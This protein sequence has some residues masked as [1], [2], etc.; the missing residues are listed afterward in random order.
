ASP[1]PAAVDPPRSVRLSTQIVRVCV[2]AVNLVGLMAMTSQRINW[3]SS[4][5]NIVEFYQ[6]TLSVPFGRAVLALARQ[7]KIDPALIPPW[8]PDYLPVA[9]IF[10]FGLVYGMAE[11]DGQTQLQFYA[12]IVKDLFR[13]LRTNFWGSLVSIPLTII[14]V[15]F[16]ALTAPAF[17]IVLPCVV[18]LYFVVAVGVASY[19]YG[20]IL[21]FVI[22]R[23]VPIVTLPLVIVLGVWLFVSEASLYAALGR[24]RRGSIRGFAR[25]RRTIRRTGLGVVRAE[26]AKI[27]TEIKT[28]GR[29]YTTV[30]ITQ[31][32]IAGALIFL[33]LTI[34]ALNYA[35]L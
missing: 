8:L 9:S 24:F 35:F 19:M 18:I 22:V 6:A 31:F 7:L 29:Q 20:S 28:A 13:E 1:A 16:F 21:L 32:R 27:W 5:A 33:F 10:T 14:I 23:V 11:A 30:I 26:M 4:L 2:A 17:A 25:A 15:L 12:E 34:T 3:R